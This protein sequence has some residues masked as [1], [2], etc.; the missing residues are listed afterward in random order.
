MSCEIKILCPLLIAVSE[1]AEP[2]NKDFPRDKRN[3]FT[4]FL[5]SGRYPLEQRIED[6]KRGIGRQKYP[7]AG[8]FLNRIILQG[9]EIVLT[10]KNVVW[11]LTIVMIGVFIWE[12]VLNAREQGSPVSMKVCATLV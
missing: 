8:A 10:R 9:V 12:L 4:K 2:T 3:A 7:F 11:A 6:K 5:A 1:Y